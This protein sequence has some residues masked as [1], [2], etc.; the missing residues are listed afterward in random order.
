VLT[1]LAAVSHYSEVLRTTDRH[2]PLLH[3]RREQADETRFPHTETPR[4]DFRLV[5]RACVPLCLFRVGGRTADDPRTAGPPPRARRVARW[6]WCSAYLEG[7][8]GHCGALEARDAARRLHLSAWC[9]AVPLPASAAF[10]LSQR[11]SP[12]IFPDVA[13]KCLS[14][15]VWRDLSLVVFAFVFVFVL[16]C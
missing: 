6:D 12:F 9:W 15:I 3:F 4:C 14:L 11:T 10:F 16:Q 7:R 5:C 1:D 13:C 8:E 2:L